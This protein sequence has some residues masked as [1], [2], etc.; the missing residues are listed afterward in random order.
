M[1][2]QRF[3]SYWS[4]LRIPS[5]SVW[6]SLVFICF[7][8][9]E[10][11]VF[12]LHIVVHWKSI[13]RGIFKVATIRMNKWP[14]QSLKYFRSGKWNK[15]LERWRI[16]LNNS[17]R[18]NFNAHFNFT[19]RLQSRESFMRIYECLWREC[20]LGFYGDVPL[21]S[22]ERVLPKSEPISA[23]VEYL[24][25]KSVARIHSMNFIG[26]SIGKFIDFW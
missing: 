7:S 3:F 20:S 12:N 5:V 23:P 11:R 25:P 17:N 8:W 4:S 26:H 2:F 14:D 21:E 18:R 15:S 6:V 19:E 1:I 16:V 9:S 24:L 10:R 22:C 13:P